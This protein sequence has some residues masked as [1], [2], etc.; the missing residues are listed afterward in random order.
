MFLPN[1][2]TT[3]RLIAI[4]SN[5]PS[6]NTNGKSQFIKNSNGIMLRETFGFLYLIGFVFSKLRA[7]K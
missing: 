7:V 6:H 5:G 3:L 4:A 1:K 2:G